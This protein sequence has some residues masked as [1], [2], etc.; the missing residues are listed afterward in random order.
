[1]IE[2]NNT[3][4]SEKKYLL[5]PVLLFSQSGFLTDLIIFSI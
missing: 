2:L 3:G 1:L 5:S 4:D